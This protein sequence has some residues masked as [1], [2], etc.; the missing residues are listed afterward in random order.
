MDE[1]GRLEAVS[2]RG[3]WR[4]KVG[5]EA[6]RRR[7]G[8]RVAYLRREGGWEEEHWLELEPGSSE[9]RAG[10]EFGVGALRRAGSGEEGRAYGL[11]RRGKKENLE[12]EH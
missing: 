3:I 7:V 2:D 11:R 9:L 5:K 6:W 4:R 12:L 10:G 1:G 8:W